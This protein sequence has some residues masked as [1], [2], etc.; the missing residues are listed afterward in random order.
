MRCGRAGGPLECGKP[1]WY[2]H[3]LLGTVAPK[4]DHSPISLL[5]GGTHAGLEANV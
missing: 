2:T 4:S 3:S 1:H 5:P